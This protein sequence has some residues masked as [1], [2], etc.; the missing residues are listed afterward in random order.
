MRHECPARSGAAV[1]GG[2][3]GGTF[4]TPGG[5]PMTLPDLLM[6]GAPG[7]GTAALR[8]SPRTGGRIAKVIWTRN[9][10]AWTSGE[11]TMPPRRNPPSSDTASKTSSTEWTSSSKASRPRRWSSPSRSDLAHRPQKTRPCR[12]R[13]RSVM[14][15]TAVRAF[16][17]GATGWIGSDLVNGV[18]RSGPRGRAYWAVS[19]WITERVVWAGPDGG[20]RAIHVSGAASVAER[21]RTWWLLQLGQIGPS[22]SNPLSWATPVK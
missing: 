17:T 18:L 4:G 16:V 9:P 6:T 1:A 8:V 14:Q 7:A 19:F 22:Q 10:P 12:A 11:A 15:E 5:V 3:L 20:I 21:H 13:R 2:A